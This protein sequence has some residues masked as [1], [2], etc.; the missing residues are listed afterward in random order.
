[1][2]VHNCIQLCCDLCEIPVQIK[3]ADTDLVSAHLVAVIRLDDLI[4]CCVEE[5]T[6]N[7][8]RLI[9][10]LGILLLDIGKDLVQI[11]GVQRVN[12]I[13]YLRRVRIVLGIYDKDRI[14]L[15]QHNVALH[16]REHGPNAR[17]PRPKESVKL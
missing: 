2:F 12:I 8:M 3:R 4:H 5:H 11:A 7:S 15:G 10:K 13:L 1:M 9:P 17:R 6:G 14:S 16:D